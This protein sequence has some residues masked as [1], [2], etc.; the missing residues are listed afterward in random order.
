MKSEDIRE[1]NVEDLI[2]YCKDLVKKKEWHNQVLD[3][4]D[5]FFTKPEAFEEFFRRFEEEVSPLLEGKK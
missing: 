4:L 3:Q 2:Q 1:N 5:S